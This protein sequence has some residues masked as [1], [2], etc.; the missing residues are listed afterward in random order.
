MNRY[1]RVLGLLGD[2]DTSEEQHQLKLEKL[3]RGEVAEQY[4]PIEQNHEDVNHVPYERTFPP[5][6]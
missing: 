3:R 1:L 4:K 2:K 6:P 5:R